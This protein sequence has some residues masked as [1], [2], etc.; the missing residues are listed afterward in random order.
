MIL[1]QILLLL[2]QEW[3]QYRRMMLP[4][5]IPA[6]NKNNIN[7]RQLAENFSLFLDRGVNGF[8]VGIILV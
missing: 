2:F 5:R 6:R 4:A 3:Q 7:A 8:L 1:V